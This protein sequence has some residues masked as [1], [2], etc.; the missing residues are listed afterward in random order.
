MLLDQ[1]R[2]HPERQT[3]SIRAECKVRAAYL[4]IYFDLIL[5]RRQVARFEVPRNMHV[6]ACLKKSINLHVAPNKEAAIIE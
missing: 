5:H 4:T 2:I 6:L 3:I 1:S